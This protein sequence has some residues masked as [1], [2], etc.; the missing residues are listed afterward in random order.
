MDFEVWC[1]SFKDLFLEIN[2]PKTIRYIHH[3]VIEVAVWFLNV[4]DLPFDDSKHFEKSVVV[5]DDA[6]FSHLLAEVSHFENLSNGLK[7]PTKIVSARL[8]FWI[9]PD[10]PMYGPIYLHLAIFAW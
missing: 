5:S 1:S 10:A 9:F 8:C 7:P 6:L 2:L 3:L 4:S